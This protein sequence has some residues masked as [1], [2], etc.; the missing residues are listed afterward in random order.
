MPQEPALRN[1][2]RGSYE[3]GRVGFLFFLEL[4]SGRTRMCPC[5]V[6]VC[7]FDVSGLCV[8]CVTC[9]IHTRVKCVAIA[10][11]HCARGATAVQDARSASADG[12][13]L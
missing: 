3:F 1:A 8:F 7:V 9:C 12:C 13:G 11:T 10:W 6:C 4:T 5:P 2:R